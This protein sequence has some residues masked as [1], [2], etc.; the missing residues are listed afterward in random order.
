[1]IVT[2]AQIRWILFSLIWLAHSKRGEWEKTVQF[3]FLDKNDV[4][5]P[6]LELSLRNARAM[7]R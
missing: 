5:G 4:I 2:D 1:M 6:D 7:W 3:F